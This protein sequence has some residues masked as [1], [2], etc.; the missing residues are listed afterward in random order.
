[1]E[2]KKSKDKILRAFQSDPHIPLGFEANIGRYNYLLFN[3]FLNVEDS[4]RWEIK[5]D[6][7]FPDC[8]GAMK[9]LFLSPQMTYSID[10]QKVSLNI[11]KKRKESLHGKELI[12]AIKGPG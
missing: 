8:I 4:F 9:K 5:Y 10:Q 12:E 3:V 7:R 1:M 11:I 2:I 6:N